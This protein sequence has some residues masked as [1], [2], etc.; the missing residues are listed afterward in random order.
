MFDIRPI[1]AAIHPSMV[2]ELKIRKETLEKET[3]R[4]TRGGITCFSELA[5]LEL[6]L[7]RLSGDKILQEMFSLKNPP[8]KKIIENGIEK[9][10]VSYEVYKKLFLYL[11]VLSK[12]KDSQQIIL[13]INKLKG[14][15]KNEILFNY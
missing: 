14:M 10:Y 12:K 15:K 11:S 4:K 9:E 5:A 1:I 3:G 6:R 7:I 2:E 8:I 13:E